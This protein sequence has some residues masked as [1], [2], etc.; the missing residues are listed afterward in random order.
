MKPEGKVVAGMDYKEQYEQEKK[1]YHK[2]QERYQEL[3]MKYEAALSEAKLAKENLAKIKNSPVWKAS[4]PLRVVYFFFKRTKTA[5]VMYGGVIGMT[6]KII[7]KL[8]QKKVQKNYGSKSYPG[9]E[10]RMEQE[11]MKFPKD[12]TFSIL[13]PLYNTPEKFLVEMITSV[14]D[15]TYK[16]W[17]LCLADGSD[18][19]H[20][21]VGEI[22]KRLSKEDSRIKYKKLEKNLGI[23]E[24]TN[25]CLKMASGEYI[26]LFD[27]DDLLHPC[28]LFENMKMICDKD[29]DYLN[30]DEVTYRG[31]Y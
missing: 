11:N 21:Y 3:D 2:L 12:I 31:F 9:P 17:E 13:V 5:Y 15:Q 4:K 25:E 22:C 30:T 26:A 8:H 18:G 20:T 28:A 7:H 16:K 23:S 6:K 24:N 14:Q 19:E 10:L 1:K 29:A 27:H